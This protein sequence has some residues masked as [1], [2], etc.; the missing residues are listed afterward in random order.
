MDDSSI[1]I[2]KKG[3]VFVM[4][5]IIGNENC[6]A[7]RKILFSETAT[8]GDLDYDARFISASNEVQFNEAIEKIKSE[9]DEEVLFLNVASYYKVKHV[10]QRLLE[11]A[12]DTEAIY[13]HDDSFI[14]EFKDVKIDLIFNARR[15]PRDIL[16]KMKAIDY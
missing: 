11:A 9:Q 2:Y 7:V 3:N 15:I 1:D 10:T 16:L 6:K 8:Q 14:E 5:P 4:Y 12:V 13:G